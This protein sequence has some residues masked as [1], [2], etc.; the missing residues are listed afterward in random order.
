[1]ECSRLICKKLNKGFGLSI[2][3]SI[4]VYIKCFNTVYRVTIL[5]KNNVTIQSLNVQ[6]EQHNP[7]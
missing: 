1:M 5:M 2:S 7:N 6:A 4:A 3:I